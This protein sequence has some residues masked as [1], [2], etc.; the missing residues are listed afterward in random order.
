M[1]RRN[2]VIAMVLLLG[3]FLFWVTYLRNPLPQKISYP[4]DPITVERGKEVAK[5]APKISSPEWMAWY[6]GL[7]AEDRRAWAIATDEMLTPPE[8]SQ[9]QKD[10][11]RIETWQPANV[12]PLFPA[13]VLFN[14]RPLLRMEKGVT[15]TMM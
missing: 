3:L 5:T 9:A 4:K 7:S 8:A 10:A 15:L 12:P 1:K 6:K 2:V 11:V 14:Y 13:K